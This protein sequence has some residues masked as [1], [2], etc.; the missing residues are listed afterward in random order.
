M[1][2]LLKILSEEASDILT[3]I[4]EESPHYIQEPTPLDTKFIATIARLDLIDSN[5]SDSYAAMYNQIQQNREIYFKRI[6]RQSG[7]IPKKQ[8]LN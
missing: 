5:L 6:I 2:E 7:K 3:K 4:Q 1:K 8:T